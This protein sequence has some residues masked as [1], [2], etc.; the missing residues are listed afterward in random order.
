MCFKSLSA[1]FLGCL[2]KEIYLDFFE[3]VYQYKMV[4]RIALLFKWRIG[5]RTLPMF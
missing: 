1:V 2:I 3:K 4:V 5:A